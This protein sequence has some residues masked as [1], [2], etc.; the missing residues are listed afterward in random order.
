ML[1]PLGAYERIRETYISYLDTA[2]R[3][4]E[5]RLAN[6]R[7][8]LL[9]LPGTLTTAPFIEP[10][11]RYVDAAYLLEELVDLKKDNPLG[12]FSHDARRAFAELALSGLFDGE[13]AD[14]E[15]RR[16]S[17]YFPY[18]HQMQMLERGVK[19][20]HPGI[21]TSGTGSGKT[22]SFMLPILAQIASEA[23]TWDAPDAGYLSGRWWEATPNTFVRHRIGERRP[24]AMRAMVLYPMNALVEDQLTRLRKTLD[25]DEAHEVMDNR[26]NGNRIF[27]G[28]YT[29]ATPVAGHLRHPRRP[30][31]QKEIEKA[32]RRVER[33]AK[34][35]AAF[36][37]DQL[38]ARRHDLAHVDDDPTRYLFPSTDS[39]E[40]VARWDMHKTPPD[41]LVTNVSML[42]TMLSREIEQ[43]MFENTRRWLESEDEAYFFLVLDEL[44]LV[45]GSSGTE[46]SGLVRTL[47][48]RLGLADPKHRHKLRILASSAS[49]PVDGPEGARSLKYLHDFFGPLGTFAGPEDK[50]AQSADEWKSAIVPG[51]Q[52]IATLRT[53]LPLAREPF[54]ALLV[55]VSPNGTFIGKVAKSDALNSLVGDCAK[56]LGLPASAHILAIE[57][58]AAVLTHAAYS[59]E[60]NRYRATSADRLATAIFGD[61]SQDSLLALRGLT[62]LRGLGDD[63]ATLFGTRVGEKTTS[64]REHVFIRSIEGLFATPVVRD[65][66]VGFEGLTVE[67]GT[68]YHNG[69][70]GP[71]RLFELVYC[72]ACGEEFVAGRRGEDLSNNT[73][74]KVELLPSSPELESLPEIGATG[75]YEDLS[76]EE[77]AVFWP[78]RANPEQGQ[79]TG[80]F[81]ERAV[82]DVRN[83]LVVQVEESGEGFVPGRIFRLTRQAGV[84]NTPGSAGPHCCPACGTDYDARSSTMRRSPIRSFRTGFAKSSQLVATELFT[85]LH[86]SGATAKAV[87]FSDSRQDASR[88]ALD[89]ERRHHQDAM[90][91]ILVES[92]ESYASDASARR[93]EIERQ[94]KDANRSKDYEALGKLFAELAKLSGGLDPDRIPLNAVIET[95][96]STAQNTGPMLSRMIEIGMHPTDDAGIAKI[97][98]NGN[99]FEWNELFA[100]AGGP[101]RWI[102][103]GDQLAIAQA[104]NSI[105]AAMRPL[106]DEVLF[107]KTYFALEETGIGYPSLFGKA[108]PDADRMDA[109]LR[110]FADA[111]RVHG[112]K[113]VD[114]ND[115]KKEWVNA[116]AVG[117]KRLKKFA[118]ASAAGGNV[119]PELDLVLS[120]LGQLQHMHGLIE[121][122]RLFV[123]LVSPNADY[124][125]CPKCSRAHLHRGTGFC[126]R[127]C[128]PLDEQPSGKAADLRRANVLSRT[129]EEND[130]S[131][132]S[133][134]RLRSEELTG[135]TKSPAERLRRFK[136]IF[137]DDGT[138]ADK[139]LLRK[140]QEID[141]L[142]VTT[143]MEVGIDIGSLQAVYQ[144]NMP[145]QRFNYQQRV[146]RA[147]RRGQAFSMVATLC[148]SRSHD[149]HY[150][151]VPESITGD[152]PP[153]PFLTMDHLTIPLRLLRKSW[154]GAAF[155]RL[156]TQSGVNFPGD[157]VDSDVHGE[158]VPASVYYDQGENWP[159]QLRQALLETVDHRDRVAEVLGVGM[160]GRAKALLTELDVH[161][162]MADLEAFREEGAISPLNLAGFLAERGLLPMYGMPTRVRD[163]IVG[164][165]TNDLGRSEWDTVDRDLDI[166]IYEF[167]PGQ[168]LVRDKQKHTAIGFTAP[169]MPPRV[170]VVRNAAFFSAVSPQWFTEETHLATCPVCG[171]TN[172]S[173]I[174]PAAPTLCADCG[175]QIE[176]DLYRLYHSPAAFR[177]S[178]RPDPA[179][180]GPRLRA[181]RREVSSEIEEVQ[182]ADVSGTN[183]SFGAG[184]RAAIVRRNEGPIGTN[185]EPEG[186]VIQA[187]TQT[188]VLVQRSPRIWANN[189][190]HQYVLPDSV[191][192][193]TWTVAVDAA[194][195]Q[196][197]A[198]N[199]MLISRKQTD[200][201]YLAMKSI[202]DGLAFQRLGGRRA[203]GTSV[204]AAAVSATQ[205]LLQRAALELDIGP[206]EFETLEPRL[207][208]GLPL[209]QVADFLVNGAGF[210][211]RLTETVGGKP[212]VLT[213]LE[214]MI[215]SDSDRLVESYFDEDHRHTC[216]RSC[217]RCAQRYNNRGY[218][219]L[220][221]W[222]LG[223]S[224]LR[225]MLD[226]HWRAGLDGDWSAREISDWPAIA[227]NLAEELYRLDPGRRTVET[228]GELQL[229][230]VRH[231]VD[232][233]TQAFVVVHPFWRLDDAEM[234]VELRTTLEAVPAH[235]VFTVDSFDAARRPVKALDLAKNRDRASL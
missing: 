2:F 210:S 84:T 189:L 15:V 215:F 31:D 201:F 192:P 70:H 227:E 194:G 133:T 35:M 66:R 230:V 1:D 100:A 217:Y 36:A 7:R 23:V 126:T 86:A 125:A 225:S 222:R 67:R 142:S 99:E 106:V 6:D 69:D 157:D 88:A 163:L 32:S 115:K 176:T 211:R 159:D 33:V 174:P 207:R 11:P 134:F 62:I 221:D 58:A 188:S 175:T 187:A 20:G 91:Q 146:G 40:L 139:I 143:T 96:G 128:M 34:S 54:R 85:A 114:A 178:F 232:G 202:P 144:A 78:T 190:R 87:V 150:F 213:L 132:I 3:I 5:P 182:T 212:L 155:G 160:A 119:I 184:E 172:S 4:R 79:N 141:M 24:A 105:V 169:I 120:R 161:R 122:E 90:R 223:L 55:G 14:G 72:E 121:P 48:E 56:A 89:I 112:N 97:I 130:A 10:V 111:Y 83:G 205:L 82:L 73:G 154:L 170:D 64:F 118:E 197:Q 129:I 191:V 110:V 12:R 42:S 9:R 103:S 45:R 181:G 186:F 145:P 28:R 81:W 18:Q 224:F 209:L 151:Q 27:F 165:E 136:G 108:A 153:P 166:A 183:F 233:I 131:G 138:N 109:Y 46:I 102:E 171:G 65:G 98:G 147:G 204:R 164:V 226:V 50:G 37:A 193:G 229:P 13:T 152:A 51:N 180:D 49:L 107:S 148:R 30:N 162:V 95:A 80:E 8:A 149:L 228:V 76:Y 16:K 123:R 93:D 158:F 196:V 53:E 219:G 234:A 74:I 63:A 61:A 185:G 127:C 214:S 22:E 94:I 43:E 167:A 71:R 216:T 199:V 21:V 19:P 17:R 68:A 137:V 156:R 25:S 135:Q 60:D 77:F 92:L 59:R 104:R 235:E 75:N 140:A 195:L 208:R 218:H 198:Q 117:S 101:P 124:Y 57:E 47:I 44:H 206:E 29:S 113:W 200:S 52:V 26:L 41:I 179:D 39:A 38:M 116:H 173:K 168:S 220:L 177:T 203:T 231:E